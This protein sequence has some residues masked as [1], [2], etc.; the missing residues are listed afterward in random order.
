LNPK[1]KV[2]TED[3]RKK[4][5]DV[6][7]NKLKALEDSLFEY[8]EA[9]TKRLGTIKDSVSCHITFKLI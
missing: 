5:A 7:E 2:V 1:S 9:F 8:Q 3:E 4:R 6:L